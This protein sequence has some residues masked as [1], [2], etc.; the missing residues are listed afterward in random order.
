M[1]NTPLKGYQPTQNNPNPTLPPTSNVKPP[2]AQVI[3]VTHG[4]FEP[5]PTT[6][7]KAFIELMEWRDANPG[8]VS[9]KILWHIYGAMLE[10]YG[11]P[12]TIIS[13]Q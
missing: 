6:P 7:Q 10:G 3:H 1:A 12:D 8:K 9:N 2:P 4:P 5:K 11:D 13:L